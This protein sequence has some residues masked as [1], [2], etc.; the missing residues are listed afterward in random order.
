[1]SAET[2]ESDLKRTLKARMRSDLVVNQQRH[3]GQ[4]FY[5]LK[6]P[7][8]LKYYRFRPEEYFL[9]S[10]LDGEKDLYDVQHAFV[11]EFSPQRLAIEDLERFVRQ[12]LDAG[13]AVVD[14]PLAGKRLYERHRQRKFQKV[15]STLSN[16]MYIRI[17]LFDPERILDRMLKW[18]GFLFTL[19]FFFVACAFWASAGLL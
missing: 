2:V 16:F 14:S 11:A 3:A 8:S 10:Q 19:P 15:K 5:I 4:L 9:L 18:F 17:P 7:V 1:M 13:V 6:D 12:L